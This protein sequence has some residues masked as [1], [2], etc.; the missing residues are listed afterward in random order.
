MK[1]DYEG[2]EKGMWAGVAKAKMHEEYTAWPG[3]AL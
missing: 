3:L 2:E 1:P